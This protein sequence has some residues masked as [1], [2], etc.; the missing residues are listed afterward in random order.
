[1][2]TPSPAPDAG[3]LATNLVHTV[4]GQV[5]G[6]AMVLA[7]V[8]VPF[9]LALMAIAVVMSKFGLNRHVATSG[10]AAPWDLPVTSDEHQMR[11]WN[12]DAAA[13]RAGGY[14]FQ[15]MDLDAM[16]EESRTRQAPAPPPPAWLREQWKRDGLS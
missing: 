3:V 1:M 6:A 2:P 16:E 4:G 11:R 10:G 9:L 8:A 14:D 12:A 15:P 5:M 7:V 13:Y